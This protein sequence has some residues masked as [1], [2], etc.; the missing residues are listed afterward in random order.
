MVGQSVRKMRAAQADAL[1]RQERTNSRFQ[2]RLNVY[3]LIAYNAYKLGVG[4]FHSGTEIDGEGKTYRVAL[5]LTRC[6]L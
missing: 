5:K 3:D 4:A 1:S 6:V 2:I